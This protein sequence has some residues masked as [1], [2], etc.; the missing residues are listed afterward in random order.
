[1]LLGA[2]KPYRKIGFI[3]ALPVG[4]KGKIYGQPFKVLI[5]YDAFGGVKAQI[6]E[7]EQGGG[8]ITEVTGRKGEIPGKTDALTDWALNRAIAEGRVSSG[9]R[10]KVKV[11]DFRLSKE[12]RFQETTIDVQKLK[13]DIKRRAKLFIT[14]LHKEVV[15]FNKGKDTKTVKA[16]PVNIGPKKT[17]KK[18]PSTANA[19]Y[20]TIYVGPF[21]V[22]GY[23]VP[24]HKR[25]IKLR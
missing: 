8:M 12:D 9:G 6:Y 21:S 2:C 18:K 20:K 7:D 17:T 5:Q 22:P 3:G 14:D 13:T 23:T 25:R 15:D 4:L 24:K 16:G 10:A 11:V 19:R 1:M